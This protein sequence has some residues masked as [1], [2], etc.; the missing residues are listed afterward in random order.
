MIK[1]FKPY[2]KAV[3]RIFSKWTHLKNSVFQYSVFSK[4]GKIKKPAFFTQI[5][6]QSDIT[7]DEN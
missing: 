1:E 7:F 3:T 6:F 2:R 5:I 4:I